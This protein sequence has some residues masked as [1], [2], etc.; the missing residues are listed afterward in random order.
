MLKENKKSF[1]RLFRFFDT[2]VVILSLFVA[3]YIRFGRLPLFFVNQTFEFEIFSFSYVILWLFFS[4]RF[5]LYKSMRFSTFFDDTQ[6]IFKANLCCL[7]IALLPTF[8]FREA[9]LSRLFI[10]YFWGGLTGSLISL[11]FFIKLSL[12]YIRL[13]G[14]NYRQVVVI[15]NNGRE[16]ISLTG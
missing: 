8:F 14:Y 11:R 3:Y 13:R 4:S 5:H 2:L 1:N 15:G 6:N 12:K 7:V 10:F 16:K 9:P